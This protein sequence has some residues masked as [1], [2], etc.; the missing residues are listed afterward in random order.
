M[1]PDD[2]RIFRIEGLGYAQDLGCG[3][4]GTLGLLVLPWTRFVLLGNVD[5][6]NYHLSTESL[7]NCLF[8][9][10][11]LRALQLSQEL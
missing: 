5:R 9:P 11:K 3:V 2:L 7:Q 10:S 8:S 1:M 6:Q 4:Q